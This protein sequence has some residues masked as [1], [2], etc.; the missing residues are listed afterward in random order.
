MGS[1]LCKEKKR[2]RRSS[3]E[4][5]DSSHQQQQQQ[6]QECQRDGRPLSAVS[7]RLI[8]DNELP[9]PVRTARTNTVPCSVTIDHLV[10]E[11]LSVIRTLVEK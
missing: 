2:R 1:C 8:I 7:G 3:S 10:L 5:Q 4:Q 9:L 11:T 6:Q